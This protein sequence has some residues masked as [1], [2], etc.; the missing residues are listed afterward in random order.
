MLKMMM[1]STR[2]EKAIAVCI[3]FEFI[4]FLPSSLAISKPLFTP[5]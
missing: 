1:S 2:L 4:R 5:A 3:A